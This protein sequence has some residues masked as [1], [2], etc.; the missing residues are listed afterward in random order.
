MESLSNNNLISIEKEIDHVMH[1]LNLEK[2]IYGKS[3]EIIYNIDT[4]GFLVPPLT[5][6]PIVENAVKH[7]IGKKEDGGTITITVSETEEIYL[8]TVTDNGAG[9]D[10]NNSLKN[11]DEQIG[12][13]N[14]RK[15]LALCGGTLEISGKVDKGT[16]AAIALPK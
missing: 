11:K 16:T 6:Q 5:I 7:G 12:V 8:I 2:A 4:G 3:L 10:M 15:R 9:Y 1:Y 13:D 14:V